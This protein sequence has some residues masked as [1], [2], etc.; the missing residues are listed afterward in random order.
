[1][2]MNK[3]TNDMERQACREGWSLF[4]TQTPGR[5]TEIER[6][7]CPAESIEGAPEEPILEDD[8]DA[9]AF[10]IHQA[11]LGSE[12]HIA[13]LAIHC[14]QGSQ[15]DLTARMRDCLS[16]LASKIADIDF[17]DDHELRQLDAKG[18]LSRLSGLFEAVDEA[19]SLVKEYDDDAK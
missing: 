18:R 17:G 6:L 16:N 3:W 11:K 2:T 13:A 5:W 19:Q 10:V 7:D 1:M 8:E 14:G 4:E 9:V 12:T 15:V